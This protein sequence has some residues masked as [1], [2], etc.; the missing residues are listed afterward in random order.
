MKIIKVLIQIECAESTRW[1]IGED[2]L[3]ELL[4]IKAEQICATHTKGPEPLVSALQ[5]ECTR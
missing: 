4:K 1:N 3:R 5:E 2:S